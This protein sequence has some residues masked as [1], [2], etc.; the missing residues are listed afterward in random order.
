[1]KT[2]CLVVVWTVLACISTIAAF[3]QRVEILS[4]YTV[5]AITASMSLSESNVSLLT[6]NRLRYQVE[7]WDCLRC[8]FQVNSWR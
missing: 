1:M 7:T 8:Q 3:A 2:I 4:A 5:S 6:E